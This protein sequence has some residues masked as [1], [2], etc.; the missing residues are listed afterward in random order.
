MPNSNQNQNIIFP[1]DTDLIISNILQKYKLEESDDEFFDK[2]EKG[3]KTKGEIVAELIKNVATKEISFQEL[4]S[5]LKM[6]L[7]ISQR[8]SEDLAKDIRKEILLLVKKSTEAPPPEI[9][10]ISPKEKMSPKKDIYRESV[11]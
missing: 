6:E 2:F 9:E 10:E 8:K 11:E 5:T 3:E 4:V 7:N 1:E